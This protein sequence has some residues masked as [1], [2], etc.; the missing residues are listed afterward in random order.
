MNVKTMLIHNC[1]VV[2]AAIERGGPAGVLNRRVVIQPVQATTPE[3]RKTSLIRGALAFSR[4]LAPGLLICAIATVIAMFVNRLLPTVN[5]LVVA[6]AL[7]ALVANT[8]GVGALLTNGLS[9]ASKKLLR[10]GVALLGVQLLLSDV[11][12]LG[13]GVVL[14]VIATVALG[15]A[16]TLVI[17]KFL[18]LSWTQRVLIA[19]GFSICGAAAVAAVDSVVEAEEDETATAIA[20]VAVF[21][22]LMILAIPALSSVLGLGEYRAGLWAGGAIQEVAQVVAAAGAIGGSA[23]G[24]AV[25]VKLARVLMLA[26]VIAVLSVVQ[27]RRAQSSISTTKRPPLVPLFV[28]GF[29]LCA[30]LRSSEV[31]PAT[32]VTAAGFMQTIFLSSAMFALG[33]GVRL[34]TLRNV[35]MKPIALAIASTFCVAVIALAGMLL[36]T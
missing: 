9:F 36:A 28:M 18:G 2:F 15:I 22:T 11:F 31:L 10:T 14:A 13:Y 12:A 3:A 26:P 19:S 4:S 17:G 29:I 16:T 21:G 23:L 5:P 8:V 30:A 7:G 24:V 34:A 25:V 27:R 6:I 1:R 33:T 20:L 32:A 35:G